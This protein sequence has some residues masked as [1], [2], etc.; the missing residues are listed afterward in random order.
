MLGHIR[1]GGISVRSLTQRMRI[2]RKFS[3]T[4]EKYD[5]IVIGGGPGGYVAAIKAGQLGMKVACVEG[6]GKLGGTCLNVG[7]IPSKSLLNASHH[8]HDAEHNF[9]KMGIE[10]TGLSL[11]WEQMQKS[12]SKAVNGLTSGIEYLF[13]KNKVDYVAGWG[14][15]TGQNEVTASLNEGGEQKLETTNIVI[16]TGSEPSKLAGVEVDEETIVTSTGALSLAKVPKTMAVIGG[17][18]IGLEMGSVYRRLGTD[19][20]VI[21]F[22]DHIIPGTDKDIT[23]TFQRALKKQGFKFKFQTAVQKAE[24][25][26]SGV[27]L[28]CESV[29]TG[30]REELEAEII[31]LSTGRWPYTEGLG[32]EEMGIEMD[33]RMVKT[34]SHFRTNIPNIYAIGDVIK[35]PMLAHK[36]EEE[37]IA[38]VEYLHSGYGH[39]NYNAIPGVI[40]THPEVATVG[41]TEEDVKEAGIPYNVGKF[42]FSANSRA[43]CNDDA[44]GLVK[45]ITDKDTDKILGAHI[46]GPA[47]GELIAELVLAIE[48]GGAAEDV[49]RTCHAHPT[50]SEALKE[51]CMD[52]YDNPIHF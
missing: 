48:Y 24:K 49:G 14:K 12:K 10:T 17:G 4:G 26:D 41:K 21:E 42:P 34:D 36:A 8:Y 35:G 30:E 38:I 47:A 16:A 9:K 37:G 29:K 43:R 25:N 23:N 39:V 33:G 20:T 31:L 51:A 46:V 22:L 19:V 6:R 11:N 40:Y 32:L 45:I 7:C 2:K 50:L 15:I 44:E 18:V 13:K 52:A 3:S 5:L 27:N 1:C 28:T